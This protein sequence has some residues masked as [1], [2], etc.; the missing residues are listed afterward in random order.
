MR[1]EA[2]CVPPELSVLAHGHHD[3]QVSQD[4]HQH[5]QRQEADQG[6]PLWHAVAM[7]TAEG[8]NNNNNNT[9]VQMCRPTNS[10][11]VRMM[12]GRR[13]VYVGKKTKK[14][15]S[16]SQLASSAEKTAS[17]HVS[18]SILSQWRGKKPIQVKTDSNLIK[19]VELITLSGAENLLE[20]DAASRRSL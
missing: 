5:D 19:F 2:G 7:E 9:L 10:R 11:S 4:A 16:R 17:L 12:E 1:R 8:H 18:Q 20:R 6:H 15:L 3:Q 14:H 13:D